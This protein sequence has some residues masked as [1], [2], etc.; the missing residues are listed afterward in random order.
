M[1]TVHSQLP[2]ALQVNLSDGPQIRLTRTGEHQHDEF[3]PG[4]PLTSSADESGMFDLPPCLAASDVAIRPTLFFFTSSQ[5]A[6]FPGSFVHSIFNSRRM[7][8]PVAH[9]IHALDSKD[10]HTPVPSI[11]FIFL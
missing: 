6:G 7:L 11:D 5:K 9:R 10:T 2:L 3:S 4:K 1:G 8:F